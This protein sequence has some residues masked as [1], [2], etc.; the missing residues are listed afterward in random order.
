LNYLPASIANLIA[1]LEPVFTTV[2]AYLLFGER[3]NGIQLIGGLM[4]LG[5]VIFLRIH[6]SRLTIHSLSA[7]Q[8][9]N[10]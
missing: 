5:S 6:E 1:T 4:I 8:T 2:S 10:N 7:P 3:L 9:S